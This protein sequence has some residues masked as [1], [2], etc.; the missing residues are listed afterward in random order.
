MLKKFI[1]LATMVLMLNSGVTLTLGTYSAVGGEVANRY[2]E[3]G[4]TYTYITTEDG[5]GWVIQGQ[6][7]EL[8]KG[9]KYAVIFDNKRTESLYDDE[10]IKLIEL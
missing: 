3:D 1:A 10:I 7:K 6:H 8:H 5:N 4:K 9:K 2:K